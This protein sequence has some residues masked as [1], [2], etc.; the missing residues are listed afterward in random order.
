MREHGHHVMVLTP[1][2]Y[3]LRTSFSSSRP[4]DYPCDS[5]PLY[6]VSKIFGWEP[7]AARREQGILKGRR[8]EMPYVG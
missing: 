5:W 3:S 7:G 6:F 4:C 2:Y 1:L 8:D